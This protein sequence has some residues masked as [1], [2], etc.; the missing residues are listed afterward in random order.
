[1]AERQCLETEQ[2]GQGGT[3]SKSD[4][5]LP[6][7]GTNGN[8][9]GGGS[10]WAYYAAGTDAGANGGDGQIKLSYTV[11]TPV[12]KTLTINPLN[13]TMMVGSTT[14]FAASGTDQFGNSF[15][16]TVTWSSSS[17]TVGTIISTGS[18]TA[19]FTAGASAGTTT[20]TATV[21]SVSTSTL[22][23]VSNLPRFFPQ[24]SFYQRTR[25]SLLAEQCPLQLRQPINTEILSPRF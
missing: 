13:P 23:T 18:S 5:H 10:G 1:M 3:G 2:F 16:I 25:Q 12:L 22:V 11:Q 9:G 19:L 7:A 4:Y 21:G 14:Q 8:G 15:P 6:V 17:S 24:L 20:V